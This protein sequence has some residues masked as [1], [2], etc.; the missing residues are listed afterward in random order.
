MN[1][2]MN[3]NERETKINVHKIKEVKELCETMGINNR[4]KLEDVESTYLTHS[5]REYI[6]YFIEAVLR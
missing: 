4:P 5:E 1:T 2:K 3:T 6:R